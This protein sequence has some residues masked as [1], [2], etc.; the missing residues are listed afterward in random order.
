MRKSKWMSI[1]ALMVIA[2]MAISM[3]ACGSKTEEQ[4]AEEPAQEEEVP[5]DIA[6]GPELSEDQMDDLFDQ[7]AKKVLEVQY[8]DYMPD[9]I[10]GHAEPFSIERDG[11]K[12]VWDVY[13]GAGEYVVLDGKTYEVS[14]SYGEAILTFDY[15][16]DGPKLTDVTWS[17]DGGEHDKWIE[18]NFNEEAVAAWKEFMKDEKNAEFIKEVVQK[19]ASDK[20]GVPAETENLLEID[21][22]AKT[23]EIVKVIE[24]GDPE[25]GTYQF[26]TETIKEG[27]LEDLK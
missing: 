15:T 18:K 19:K 14:G 17:A 13:L 21:K 11:D 22:D 23:Y 9:D 10:F 26:D 25:D 24:S 20:F 8:G 5:E 27:K 12:G 16:A 4:P 2:V 1:L 3:T 6:S 7:A